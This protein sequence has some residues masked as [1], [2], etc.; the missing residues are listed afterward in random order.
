MK[1]RFRTVGLLVAC[2]A[3]MS[4]SACADHY[5]DDKSSFDLALVVKNATGGA[6]PGL[7]AQ[8][9]IMDTD[10]PGDGR[11]PVALETKSTDVAGRA[12]WTYDAYNAPYIV[13]YEVRNSSGD[14]LAEASPAARQSL[15]G[16]PG[17]CQVTLP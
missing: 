10:I 11:A 15:E 9:W 8:V 6:V 7:A 17:E 14:L 13:G 12:T 2:A 16:I 1:G 5:R 3:A 4:L